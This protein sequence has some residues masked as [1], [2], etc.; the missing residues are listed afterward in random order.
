MAFGG[1]DFDQLFVSEAS[2]AVY[3]LQLDEPGQRPF[4]GPR[5]V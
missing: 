5:S 3:R 4:A 1:I 2:G